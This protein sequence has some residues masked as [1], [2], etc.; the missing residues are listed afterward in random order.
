M[1]SIV[2]TARLPKSIG[3][4]VPKQIKTVWRA[5]RLQR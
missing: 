4:G 3:L 5:D 2:A 1:A